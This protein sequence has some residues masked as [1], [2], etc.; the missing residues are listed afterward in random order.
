MTYLEAA[1]IILSASDRPLKTVE[2]TERIA[3]QNLLVFKGRTP[4]ATL[5]ASLYRA[6][7]KHPAL[8]RDAIPGAGRATRGSVRW[9]VVNE[10]S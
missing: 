2:I 4:A 3:E 7:G 6:L 1:I 10:T 8:R 5:S 9:Y